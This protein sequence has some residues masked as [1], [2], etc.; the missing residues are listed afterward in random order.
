M[1][2][3]RRTV[4]QAE[5]GEPQLSNPQRSLLLMNLSSGEMKVLVPDCVTRWP[6]IQGD[7]VLYASDSPDSMHL[8][9]LRTGADQTLT[10]TTPSPQARWI[11]GRFAVWQRM[12]GAQ[13]MQA[14]VCDTATGAVSVLSDPQDFVHYVY[15][16]DR[17]VYWVW[18]T[19]TSQGTADM[20]HVFLSSVDLPP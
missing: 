7:S 15:V 11:A 12:S 4:S 8:L 18:S 2:W 17:R 10:S 16:A 9:D 13:P 1:V 3:V 5:E 19:W 20:T 6:I 14:I